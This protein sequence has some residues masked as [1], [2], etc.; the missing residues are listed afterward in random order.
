MKNFI[1]FRK[2]LSAAGASPL[3]VQVPR[4]LR[5][6]VV[7]A[8]V[9]TLASGGLNAKVL[10]DTVA[11]VNG[12]PILL[13]EYQKRL[14]SIIAY[15]RKASP[16]ILRSTAAVS[17]LKTKVLD[18]IVD[19]AI[20]AQEAQRQSIKVRARELQNGVDEVK[21]KFKRDAE[22]NV[23]PDE[24]GEAAFQKELKQEGLN[25]EQ[26]EDRIRNQIMIRKLIDKAIKPE[27]EVPKDSDVQEYFKRIQFVVDGGTGTL[28]GM[29]EREAQETRLVVQQ[30]K[31]A[32]SE[33]IRA[34]HILIEL[35]PKASVVEK[36]QALNKI[37]DI[38][39]DLE[40]G[41]D[42][43][44]LARAHS[45][46][47]GSA[48]RGGDLGPIIRGMMVPEF[49]KAAFALAVGEISDIVQTDFGY[50]I[51]RVEE[52]KAAQKLN[53]QDVKEEMRQF[54]YNSKLQKKLEDLVLELRRTAKIEVFLPKED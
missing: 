13:S 19:D 4:A 12:K 3:A 49:E 48:Q 23:L 46:D 27:V 8:L 18:Q 21:G 15:Y 37:K 10:D 31:E 16:G 22:G 54:L 14:E 9:L 5:A 45:E 50:H 2:G 11:T 25:Y 6:A 42:F 1:D 34:R 51:I 44:E 36:S 38:Q 47:P 24:E 52:K 26:F 29:S 53:F 41:E 17:E 43:A 7:A 35:P 28:E 20:L 30:I 32:T 40:D 33:R 39:K